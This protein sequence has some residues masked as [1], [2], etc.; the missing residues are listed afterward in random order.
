MT[1]SPS[2]WHI[3]VPSPDECNLGEGLYVRSAEDLPVAFASSGNP[4]D[5]QLIAAAP[6]LLDELRRL[7]DFFE[8]YLSGLANDQ[9]V[10]EMIAPTY[11]LLARIED[12]S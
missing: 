10:D 4:V 8:R 2:P 3:A 7:A 6:E 9:Y 11:A 5:A 12:P 1:H